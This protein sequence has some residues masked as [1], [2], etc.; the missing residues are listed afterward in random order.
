MIRIQPYSSYWVLIFLFL[1]PFGKVFAGWNS[2]IVNFDKSLYG[3]G[4]Q[5][6]Q[7]A[8]MMTIGFIL[9]IRT[10]WYSLTEMSGRC[11]R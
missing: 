9:Q 4:T 2:F 5:T 3:K 1:I 8:L 11:F 10:A 7:I 6:W